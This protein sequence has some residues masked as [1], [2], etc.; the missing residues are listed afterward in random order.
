M[1]LSEAPFSL[2]PG[3]YRHF[4]VS[5]GSSK[6]MHEVEMAHGFNR[7]D[8][9]RDKIEGLLH[10]EILCYRKGYLSDLTY[11]IVT[12]LCPENKM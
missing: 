5:T 11:V 8:I 6:V 1:S 9:E 7:L 12:H 10:V 4:S 2:K 3:V